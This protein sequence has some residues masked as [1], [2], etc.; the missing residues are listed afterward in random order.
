MYP[1]TPPRVLATKSHTCH[2]RI[3]GTKWE[4]I[5]LGRAG[6]ILRHDYECYAALRAGMI[7]RHDEYCTALVLFVMFLRGLATFQIIAVLV[8]RSGIGARNPK[9]RTRTNLSPR[10]CFRYLTRYFRWN[11]VDADKLSVFLSCTVCSGGRL[12][13]SV[14]RNGGS[15]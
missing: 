2:D 6:V 5:S 8:K 15:G 4:G 7:L 12:H 3:C 14:Q 9:C 11:R 1:S 10:A 13:R